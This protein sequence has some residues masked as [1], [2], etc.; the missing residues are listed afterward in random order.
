M[1]WSSCLFPNFCSFCSLIVWRLI[2]WY[3]VI[4]IC[5]DM[6][7]GRAIL[8]AGMV[9]PAYAES[10]PCTRPR[11]RHHGTGLDRTGHSCASGT[12]KRHSGIPAT[13]ACRRPSSPSRER[14]SLEEMET[15]RGVES[16]W[17]RHGT[18]QPSQLMS[19]SR[20][21]RSAG[22]RSH[23][24]PCALCTLYSVRSPGL[25]ATREAR[26]QCPKTAYVQRRL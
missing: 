18:G 5:I 21:V 6:T 11:D 9:Y 4:G 12:A 19:S 14:A 25:R 13:F 17:N 10:L 8:H 2:G 15:Q 16:I 1:V 23:A 3:V 24:K 26:A 20:V 7:A 22:R